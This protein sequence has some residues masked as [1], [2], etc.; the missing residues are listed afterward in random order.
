VIR[1]AIALHGAPISLRA[2]PDL[3]RVVLDNLIGN[4]VKYGRTGTEIRVIA[5]KLPEGIG[6]EVYNHGVGVPRERLPELFTKFH[7]IQDPKLPSRK[8]TGVGLYL[9]KRFVDL[10]GGRVGV[11]G[12]YGEWIRFWFEIPQGEPLELPANSQGAGGGS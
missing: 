8:G 10:H 6:V 3:M 4:A 12:E 9:V 2:D 11:D 5:Q 1:P 7:R